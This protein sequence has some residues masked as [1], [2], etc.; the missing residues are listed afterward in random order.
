[1]K[2]FRNIEKKIFIPAF[3]ILVMI[4]VPIYLIPDQVD[5]VISVLFAVCTGEF[6][7]L[8]LLTCLASFGFLFW[9]S[10]SKYGDVKLGSPEEKPQYKDLSWIAMLF[11]AGVGTSIIILGFLEPI[12]YVSGPPFDLEPFSKEA[13]EYAHMYG[14]FH[15]GFSAWAIYNP[16]IIA[17]AYMMFVRREKKMRLSAAC[18]SVIGKHADGWPGHLIDILVVFGIVGSISTSLGI[19]APVLSTVIR[20]VFGIPEQ[21]DFAVCVLVLII[22]VLIFGTSVYL[23]L[24]KGI[25]N[26]S[27]I[28]VVLA[29]VFMLI[30]L[31]A[32][33]TIDIFKMEVNSIGLYIS[34]FVRMSTYTDPFGNGKFTQEWTAFYWGWWLAFMPM[35]GMFVAKISRGRTIRNVAC[36]Q[37]LWGTLG[38]CTS[39]M[40]FGGYS[41]YLQKSGTVDLAGILESQGQSAAIVAIMETLPLSRFM[42]LFLCIV[43]FVYLATTIDSCAYVLAGVTT[44]RLG[45]QEEPARWNRIVWAILFCLLSIGLMVIGG[46]EAVKTISV[47]TGLPLIAVNFILMF[48]VKKMLSESE[49]KKT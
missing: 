16:A 42:M 4:L 1:M 5:S 15:W 37:L 13:Y 7:W 48:S 20:E 18:R 44:K 25:Q 23:G 12:Y 36:G 40:I 10:F 33:P 47:L 21:Y 9:I 30:V 34:Q 31:L 2:I 3:L 28:N 19:G 29:F 43:C 38:C 46:L 39:F 24:D 45:D 6:G 26:L 27:N 41:L 35:M 17:T 32:G 49:K 14:Q 11:T 8:F 22:W